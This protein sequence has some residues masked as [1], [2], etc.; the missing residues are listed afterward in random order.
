MDSNNNNNNNNNS[1]NNNG[2]KKRGKRNT[3]TFI[4]LANSKAETLWS[5]ICKMYSVLI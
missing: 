4:T 1:R 5:I 3:W 2:N